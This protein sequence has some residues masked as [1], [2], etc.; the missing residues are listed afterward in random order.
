[1]ST[2]TQRGGFKRKT[3]TSLVV[4]MAVIMVFSYH[5]DGAAASSIS[6]G[7]YVQASGAYTGEVSVGGVMN[8]GLSQTNSEQKVKLLGLSPDST[9]AMTEWDA[10]GPNFSWG[11]QETVSSYSVTVPANA[12]GNMTV[13]VSAYSNSSRYLTINVTV[14]SFAI[15]ANYF[16]FLY[17]AKINPSNPKS[18][19]ITPDLASKRGA[20]WANKRIDLNKPFNVEMD[21]YLGHD[22]GGSGYVGGGVAFVL[23]NDSRG[24]SA[25]A[26]NGSG[27]G[28]YDYTGAAYIRNAIAIEFDTY[29]NG[30]VQ[31]DSTDPALPSGYNAHAAFVFPKG[32]RITPSDHI[33]TRFFNSGQYWQKLKVQWTPQTQGGVLGGTL[34][35]DFNSGQCTG[36]YYINNVNSVFG[37]SS[38]YW[39]MTGATGG[40]WSRQEARF[41]SLPNY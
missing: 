20:M 39:G 12:T 9:Q 27:L 29:H 30:D 32:S 31:W 34:S 36:S 1:M 24:T 22:P 19:I 8:I 40:A 25:I 41:E 7:F 11:F 38:V 35:Y 4:I 33:N 6:S 15:P 2:N 13:I 17:D 37:T 16:A 10:S 28:V 5:V 18:V 26:S 21:M 3:A 14:G 23:Q